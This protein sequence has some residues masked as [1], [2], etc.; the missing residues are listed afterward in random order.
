[1]ANTF[2]FIEI[3]PMFE[4]T[5][6]GLAAMETFE[7]QTAIP[8]L[9]PHCGSWIVTRPNGEIVCETFD[10]ATAQSAAEQGLTVKTAAQHLASLNRRALASTYA[11]EI[12]YDPFEDDPEITESEVALTLAERR[13]E[14]GPV[15]IVE[16]SAVVAKGYPP[17]TE[18]AVYVG[19]RLIRTCPSIGMA[20]EI[21]AGAA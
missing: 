18:F 17:C 7:A 5:P 12:G 2:Q 15:K 9:E 3:E 6:E 14:C 21:A 11:S 8:E 19:E 4:I 20:R 13:A 1:M 16:Q 10:R